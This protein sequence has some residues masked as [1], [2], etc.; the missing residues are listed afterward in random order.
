LRLGQQRIAVRRT[1]SR[2]A[3]LGPFSARLRCD[4]L[5]SATLGRP[6]FTGTLRVR[7][8]LRQTAHVVVTV[9]RAGHTVARRATTSAPGAHVLR[10]RAL[11]RGTYRV[12][13]S[14]AGRRATLAAARP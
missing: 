1:A 11:K 10:F 12:V 9:R 13:I 8:R 3:V 2:F 14:A 6:A 7:Y 5:A 4:A